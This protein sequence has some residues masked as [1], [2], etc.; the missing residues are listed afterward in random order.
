[1]SPA[2]LADAL[3]EAAIQH[4]DRAAFVDGDQRLSFAEWE[5]RADGLAAVLVERGVRPGD[6]VAIMLPTSIDY[7]VVYGA[8][9]KAGAIATGLNV[10]LGAREIASILD[11]RS[12]RARRGDLGSPRVHDG[13]LGRPAGDRT[14]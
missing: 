4:G 13:A 11:P 7:V 2:T 9:T 1:M 5:R 6:V 12:R 3:E 8:I 14:R 10:R